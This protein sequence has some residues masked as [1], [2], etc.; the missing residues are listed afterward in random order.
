MSSINP[1]SG[2]VGTEVTIT[3]ENFSATPSEN[4]ITFN[5]TQ[6]PVNS[7]STTE[8]VTQVPEGAT[9]G[10]VEVT[11]D[12]KTGTGPD[13]DVVTTGLLDVVIATQG[14]DQD[15]DGYLVSVDEAEGIRTDI[16]ETYTQPGLEEGTHQVGISDIADNCF[17]S[18]D[19]PNPYDINITAGQTTTTNVDVQCEALN[20]PPTPSFKVACENLQC[21]FDA[22]GS[23]DSDGSIDS[24]SWDFGDGLTG[25]NQTTT[26]NYEV[27]GTY[28][29]QLTVTDNE[30]AE[31]TATKEI[32][33]TLP[34]ISSIS[35]TEGPIGTEVTISG[36]GF[37]AT[38]S[39]NEVEFT[40]GNTE[41][42]ATIKT[43]SETQLV[44]DVPGDATT[45]PVYVSTFGYRVQGPTFTVEQ[46]KFLEVSIVTSGS[47]IDSDGYTLSVEGADDRF[48]K[49][50]DNVTY[51]DLFADEVQVQLS[52]IADN[53]SVDGNN[54]RTVTLNNAD[55]AGF[56]QFDVSC[57]GVGPTIDSISPTS[58]ATGTQVTI[59][60]NNFS[61]TLSDN[62]V[63]FNGVRAELNSATTTELVAF[64]PFDATTG[65][66]EVTVNGQTA[67]GPTFTVI[68]T[69]RLEVN[70]STTGSSLDS[71]GYG[72]I[73]DGGTAS[74]V[75]IN[76][77]VA[78]DD[79]SEGS[80][81]IELTDIASNCF[82]MQDRANPY[83]VNITA[84]DTTATNIDVQCEEPNQPPTALFNFSCENLS[85][86]FDA[87]ASSDPDGFISVY[88][89]DYGDGTSSTESGS[90][91]NHNFEIPGTYTVELT[92]GDNEGA[93]DTI[94]KDVTVTLPQINSITPAEGPIGTEVTIT[95]SGF[96]ATATDN[97]VEFTSG[98]VEVQATIKSASETQLVVDVPGD[99]STGPVYVSTYGYRVQGPTF[100]VQQP[101]FLE[102]SIITS[103]SN[104]DPDG[105]TLSVEGAD[106]RFVKAN[107]NV[108]YN[109]LYADE[110][111]VQLS[112]IASNC[113]VGGENPRIVNLNNADNAGFTEFDISCESPLQGK[114]YFSGRSDSRE[115]FSI[116]PDGTNELII[117]NNSLSEFYPVVSND[118][119]K[120]AFA[121]FDG[122]GDRQLFVM[123]TDGT[124]IEQLTN[125]GGYA[126]PGGWSP[127]D[128]QIVFEYDASD[129]TDCG[130]S[131]IFTI[132]GDG[133]NLTRLTTST[134]SSVQATAPDW[135][136]DGERIVY[137]NRFD[138]Q[139]YDIMVMNSDGTNIQR[140]TETSDQEFNPRWSPDG[141]QI[142]YDS[143]E[144]FI[145]N[146]DG[147][148][149]IKLT[150]VNPT[151]NDGI[152][153]CESPSW[154]PNGNH[155]VYEC[156]DSGIYRTPINEINNMIKVADGDH[157]DWVIE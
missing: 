13:F 10:P 1:Q 85:C 6:A 101:K 156:D 123:N 20:S 81:S 155:L 21:Q 45:G 118:G 140:L 109:D 124:G 129:C 41:V 55:N 147:S 154:S 69:G 51:D 15:P 146:A 71:N 133:S 12:S 47:D 39:D 77:F 57:T 65:P 127:D 149:K 145:M 88:N 125:T 3:G 106:D 89:W 34:S 92:V 43:A 82:I 66:V 14:E 112:G 137:A 128:S 141:T 5:G 70:I 98:S 26:H 19:R 64:V 142:A 23:S 122:A 31:S 120:I 52:G 17:I 157:P 110:V 78:Y 105:Y 115:I 111:R 135:S 96:S 62:V 63:T 150:D 60:G 76:D 56:T 2:V 131:E 36:S 38:A 24:Y 59:S 25:S 102:V 4:T 94:T 90:A 91:T 75:D 44:V 46:P 67:T 100:T 7:A 73:L 50:N 79:L 108:T 40:S 8:L 144:I 61:S 53:C 29:V 130:R 86:D 152:N 58:G 148:N 74:S 126:V 99:A 49:A 27:E 80:H 114:I 139:G 103:G 134:G 72:L 113:T 42:Q 93:E 136:P 16:N 28:T 143:N 18:Q 117:T 132:N 33:P 121:S 138:P 151:A 95:G 30:G 107:D 153:Y 116:N 119:S 48:V 9:D 104:I 68:T 84:G 37:S 87:S 32:S 97:E 83:D 11:V 54:P 35:P 22:S